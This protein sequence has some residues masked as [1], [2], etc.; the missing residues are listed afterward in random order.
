MKQ[1]HP[2]SARL[3][4][5]LPAT[6][7]ALAFGLA[8]CATEVLRCPTIAPAP[9]EVSALKNPEF[10]DQFAA[11]YRFSLGRP[12]AIQVTPDDQ[13]V[14]FL[15]AAGPR[16][17]VQDL[18]I[19]DVATGQE[20]VLLTADQILGGAQE[21]LT[22]EELARRERMRSSSRGIASYTLSK[23]GSKVVVPL[24]GRLFVIDL[25]AARA[26]A[27]TVQELKSDAGFPIDPRLSPDGKLLACVRSGEIYIT[28]LA[29]AA[30]RK[31][32]SGAGGPITHGLAEFVA[33]EEMDRFAG[34]WW[35]PDASR[36]AY[37]RTDTS[38]EE[39]FYIA[40][41]VHPETAPTP[42]PYPRA[43]KANALVTLWLTPTAG[44]V[45]PTQVAWDHDA[46]PYLARVSW[47]EHGQM[48]IL[49]QNRTQTEQVLFAV[50]PATGGTTEL[51]R[52]KDSA[53]LNLP[54]DPRWLDDG[55]AFFWMT[56]QAQ[57]TDDW[58]L[59][60][61]D[62]QGKF[63]R[64]LSVPNASI[65]ALIDVH[66]KA[67][68]I[69]VA[70]T[71][72]P[73]QS[74]VIELTLDGSLPKDSAVTRATSP[75]GLHGSIFGRGHGTWVHTFSLAD[76]T[77]GNQV[78]RADGSKA[79]ELR[80]IAEEPG[81]TPNISWHTLGSQGFRAAAILP[82]NFDPAKLY[83]VI[84][85]VYGGPH[86]QTVRAAARNYLL[87]QWL[88]DQGF[89]V[90]TIDAR[91]TPGRGRA[92][93]RTIKSDVMSLPLEDQARALTLLAEKIPQMDLSRVGISGWSF[94]GYFSAM[95]TMRR[96]D[97]FKAGI[98]GA[99]VCDWRDY[100][101]H[102]TER[103][104]GLPQDNPS[105][106]DKASVLT[107]CKDLTVPLLIIHGTSD[108]NVYFLHSLKMTEA[109]FRANKHFEFLPLAGF[110]HSVPDPVVIKGLQTRTVEFFQKHLG[111]PR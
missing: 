65:D 105:G 23:D 79:G 92:W 59:Q 78:F 87:Q 37:Q 44:G 88:A 54:P 49:V 43:G 76:G 103:Y 104:M 29:S 55:K 90:V 107:Y 95:A 13:S 19:F 96:P 48:T 25:A 53:W 60:L 86:V 33:Q 3:A 84:N 32:T 82:R 67:G 12:I 58:Q 28:D 56:E 93:E 47:P 35:S 89:I 51:L 70:A 72:E 41:P 27:P 22:A 91:G 73:T 85:S 77:I 75:A 98:A 18:W 14:L 111:K 26:G 20:R 108:D 7:L 69:R 16:T 100:D 34:F 10:L 52:E 1:A 97:I 9:R 5:I 17:F 66:E 63:V 15:R 102:Y 101:T 21:T 42:W 30:E 2:R 110:T 81:F 40:D 62:A 39:T 45:A 83:P 68:V 50:D 57:G 74:R 6:L 80:S 94:G 4:R 64:A 8:G 36:I 24:S 46:F 106:Y 31:L 109:L 99:P 61:R 11:T 71:G 38:P